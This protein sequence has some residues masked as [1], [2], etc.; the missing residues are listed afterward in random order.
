MRSQ[1]CSVVSRWA[2]RIMVRALLLFDSRSMAVLILSSVLPSR[3]EVA[4]SKR[5]ISQ[6]L[7]LYHAGGENERFSCLWSI[8]WSK[9]F[10]GLFSQSA[11]IPQTPVAQG[12]PDFHFSGHGWC[13]PHTQIKCPTNWATPGYEVK[14]N[15]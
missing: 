5:R 3:E 14:K 7:L 4:S 2:I 9:P 6:F 8:L 10:L 11:K 15:C 1:Y 13:P 12:F